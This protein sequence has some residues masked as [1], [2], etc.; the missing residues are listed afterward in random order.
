MPLRALLYEIVAVLAESARVEQILLGRV[1]K[2][3]RERL[4]VYEA[5]VYVLRH[6]AGLAQRFAE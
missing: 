1:M 6:F 4:L 2:C 3:L 5:H